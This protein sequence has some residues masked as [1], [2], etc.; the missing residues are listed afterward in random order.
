MLFIVEIGAILSN[1]EEF[2]T[3]LSFKKKQWLVKVN[4]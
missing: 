1:S 2:P 4:I 3:G